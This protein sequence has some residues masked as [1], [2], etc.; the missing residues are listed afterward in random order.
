MLIVSIMTHI[1]SQGFALCMWT[2]VMEDVN[3]VYVELVF[4]DIVL[5][6]GQG[7]FTAAIFGLDTKLI[8]IP[9]LRW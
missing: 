4:L 6:F 8:V 2:L 1:P 5:N 7:F 3:G 9:L